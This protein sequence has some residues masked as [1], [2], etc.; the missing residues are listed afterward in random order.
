MGLSGIAIFKMLPKTNCKECGV[1]TCMAFAMALAGGK[2]ELSK[3]PHVSDEAVASLS[4]ASAPP[5]RTVAIGSGDRVF[6]TG[7]ESV[8][9][10]HEKTFFNPTGFAVLVSDTEDD[11]SAD[12]KIDRFYSYEYE[13]VGL[14]LRAD[15]IALQ[16]DSGDAGKFAA[17]VAKVAGK[18]N[19]PLILIGG[20][21][22]LKAGADKVKANK[23]LLY[24]NNA[25]SLDDLGALGKETGCSVGFKGEGLD[26]VA[27]GTKVLAGKDVKDMVVDTG[28]RTIKAAMDDSIALR[29]LAIDKKAHE[30]GFPTIIFANEMA[31]NLSGESMVAAVFVAKYG[32]IVVLSDIQGHSLFPLLLQRLNVFTDPQRPMKTSEGV[33]EIGKPGPDSP[34]LV[35]SNFSLTYF[36]VSGEIEASRIDSWLVVVDTDGL[37]VLTA[38][39]AGKFAGDLVGILVKKLGLNDKINTKKIIIPGLT[40]IISGDLEEELGPDWEVLIG[41][42]EA[43]HI[44]AYLKQQNYS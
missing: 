15:L 43:P 36:I 13:R 22:A 12:G 8:H 20:L 35:T 34:V 11:A 23:P 19:A 31:D 1:P 4:E 37:S 27:A 41:P 5:I 29:R 3:C 10:R 21:D 7:G 2:T 44:P 38:W 28:A 30:F 9:F 42:R 40:A 26:G 25:D 17:F 24:L 14:N 32:G 18:G 33:Y 16:C 39:A 6:K